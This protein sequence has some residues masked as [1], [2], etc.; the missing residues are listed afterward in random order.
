MKFVN[1]N[2]QEI[3]NE[4]PKVIRV[5]GKLVS[6]PSIETLN[7][8][9]WYEY[10]ERQ[11]VAKGKRALSRNWEVEDGKAVESVVA[12]D[13]DLSSDLI[14]IAHAFRTTLRNHFGPDAET[15]QTLTE[16]KVMQY[17]AGK[18]LRG[19]VLPTDPMDTMV[20][21]FGFNAIKR[22]TGDGTSWSF[23]WARV[24]AY[25]ATT[26]TTTTATVGPMQVRKKRKTK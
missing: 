12:V 20:L 19:E 8:L 18:Q 24:D 6:N 3:F 2:T 17:F 15:N 10:V 4:T 22:W 23:P 9:G 14:W 26:T 5:G 11:T 16:D 13:R 7:S 1:I 21:S 25:L